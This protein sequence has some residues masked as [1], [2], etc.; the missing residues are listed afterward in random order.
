MKCFTVPSHSKVYILLVFN[1]TVK[2][3]YK[4]S[5]FYKLDDINTLIESLNERGIRE[6]ELRQNLIDNIDNIVENLNKKNLISNFNFANLATLWK[7]IHLIEHTIH[8]IIF[9]CLTQFY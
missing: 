3:K 1:L 8:I 4:W 2:D 6:S 7:H 9:V 5:F